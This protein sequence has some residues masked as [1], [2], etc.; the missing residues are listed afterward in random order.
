MLHSMA[1]RTLKLPQLI[2]CTSTPQ[3]K[4]EIVTPEIARQFPHLKEIAD[5]I[6]CYEP[7]AKIE[8]LIGRD[9]PELLKVIASK[10]GP[11]GAPWAQRLDLGWTV[12]A[13]MCLDQ[14]GGTIHIS[15][16]CTAVENSDK[17][18]GFS[19]SNQTTHHTSV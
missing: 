4:R 14:V 8:I 11:K 17:T 10:N 15:A 13:Q 12:P 19:W 18:L 3:D 1:G 6:P 9:A 5:E 2:E 16:R 7:K